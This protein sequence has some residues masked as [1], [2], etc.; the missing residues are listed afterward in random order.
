MS[1]PNF[2]SISL[3]IDEISAETTSVAK[4]QLRSQSTEIVVNSEDGAGCKA[5]NEINSNCLVN[6]YTTH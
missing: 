2:M 5:E 3:I 4:K 1:L 6:Q